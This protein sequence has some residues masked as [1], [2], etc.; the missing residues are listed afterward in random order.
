MELIWHTELR[1]LPPD[2]ILFCFWQATE[3]GQSDHLN[4]V[5]DWIDTNR[6][7][8]L[9][10]AGLFLIGLNAD[11]NL[12][13][14]PDPS[15]FLN[16]N[17]CFLAPEAACTLLTFSITHAWSLNLAPDKIFSCF[18]YQIRELW[19]KNAASKISLL[20]QSLTITSPLFNSPDA[21]CYRLSCGPI[22]QMLKH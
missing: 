5:W 6:S 7:F 15:P 1:L 17:Y 16:G 20:W 12:R 10:E 19:G 13:C 18:F 4:G 3:V 2:R 14:W 22:I 21:F 9:N 8:N 11:R